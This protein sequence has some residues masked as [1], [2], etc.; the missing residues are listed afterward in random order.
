MYRLRCVEIPTCRPRI[1]RDHK[2]VTYLRRRQADLHL[3]STVQEAVCWRNQPVLIGT[4]TVQE[5][6]AVLAELQLWCAVTMSV[7]LCQ[8]SCALIYG[9]LLR[10]RL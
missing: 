7:C 2:P 3:C 9:K 8:Y 6:F 10:L 4:S 5:S 1:R